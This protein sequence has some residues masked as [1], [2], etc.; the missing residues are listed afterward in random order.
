MPAGEYN[1]SL[2]AKDVNGNQIKILS[3]VIG[4]VDGVSFEGDVPYLTVNGM[5]I[6]VSD[7]EEVKEVIR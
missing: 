6:P 5:K 3:N 7:V 2:S 1:F 4:I